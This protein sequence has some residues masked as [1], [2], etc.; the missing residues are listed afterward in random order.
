VEVQVVPARSSADLRRAAPI[1]AQVLAEGG[2]VIHPTE[3]VYG[4]GGD[5]SAVNNRLL[6][7]VK[8]REPDQPLLVL[9]PDL[10]ALRA[11]FPGVEWPEGAER[12]AG[13]FWPGP[14]TVVVRCPE[15]P[16]GLA[17]PGD[18]LAVRLSP[19][20]TVTGLLAVWGRPMTSSSANLSGHQPARTVEGALEML[21]NRDDLSD[22]GVPVVAL[23]AGTTGGGLPSTIVSFV[24]SPPRLLREGPVSRR[25]VEARLPDLL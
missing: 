4:I 22:I 16:E 1:A 24:E 10:D 14:L 9:V 13:Y 6:A 20:P 18:G 23:D 11:S 17:G 12:L 21:G 3:T 19:D 8:R 2:L 5:G 7:R 25:D 15:T